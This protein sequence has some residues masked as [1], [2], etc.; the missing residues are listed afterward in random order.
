[1]THRW[2]FLARPHQR[3]EHEKC[4][5]DAAKTVLRSRPCSSATFVACFPDLPTN[6]LPH[7][8]QAWQLCVP[9]PRHLPAF[10]PG[11]VAAVH[12]TSEPAPLS[13]PQGPDAP[14]QRPAASWTAPRSTVSPT[15]EACCQFPPPILTVPR[16]PWADW[17]HYYLPR[18]VG[19]QFL[20]LVQV[21]LDARRA[22]WEQMPPA[23]PPGS[24]RALCLQNRFQFTKKRWN[25]FR[26]ARCDWV[27]LAD[28]TCSHAC[29]NMHK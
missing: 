9:P 6:P 21:R 17:K 1:M 10:W 18:R 15:V 8:H 14:R 28:E 25:K 26:T 2:R 5:L 3:Q 16:D 24:T 7:H 29:P 4:R 11:N 27:E 20:S 12:E 13:S 23:L 22:E 19:P